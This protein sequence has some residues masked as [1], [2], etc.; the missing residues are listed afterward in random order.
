MKRQQ[1]QLRQNINGK[2]PTLSLAVQQKMA[3]EMQSKYPKDVFLDTIPNFEVPKRMD[4][5]EFNNKRKI[6][7]VRWFKSDAREI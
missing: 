3:G 1:E 5:C 7:D 4:H 6:T 2:A